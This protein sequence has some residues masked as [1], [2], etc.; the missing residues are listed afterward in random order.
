M[1]GSAAAI[2]GE[3]SGI[4]GTAGAQHALRNSDPAG[5]E[6]RYLPVASTRVMGK[7]GVRLRISLPPLVPMQVY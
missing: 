1:P 7:Q 6:W 4:L 5:P 3:G 2:A